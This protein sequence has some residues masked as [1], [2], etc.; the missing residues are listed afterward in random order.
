V[1]LPWQGAEAAT[2]RVWRSPLTSHYASVAAVLRVD[3]EECTAL[4][5]W[6]SPD[7]PPNYCIRTIH[8][9]APE[10]GTGRG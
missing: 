6:E 10:P 1:P 7:D 4:V 9:D 2:R 5:S 8:L 3:G